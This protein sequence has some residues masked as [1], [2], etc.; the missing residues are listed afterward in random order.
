[1]EDIEE[2]FQEYII[3]E[4]KFEKKPKKVLAAAM[5]GLTGINK[6]IKIHHEEED[7][8][9]D[10]IFTPESSEISGLKDPSKDSNLTSNSSVS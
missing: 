6:M 2:Q 8:Y 7:E 1:M 5:L 4:Q 10:G 9:S 3:R